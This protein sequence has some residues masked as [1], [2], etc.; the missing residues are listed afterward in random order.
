MRTYFILYLSVAFFA[1]G[2]SLSTIKKNTLNYLNK[3]KVL[4]SKY[5]SHS[6]DKNL[7]AVNS[8]D[9]LGQLKNIRVKLKLGKKEKMDYLHEYMKSANKKVLDN[10]LSSKSKTKKIPKSSI[11]KVHE[12]LKN[13]AI[14]NIKDNPK[15]DK[16]G[17]I[18]F[19]FG[20]SFYTHYLLR[21]I[22][23][24]Q[25]DIAKIF[26]NGRLNYNGQLWDY[27]MATMVKSDKNE[28]WVVDSLF[29]EPIK[30]KKWVKLTVMFG[31]KKEKS[32]AR[33]FITDPRK[34]QSQYGAYEKKFFEI[35]DL[36]NY[37]DKLF[38][39]L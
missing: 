5:Y 33:I 21:K 25:I 1:Y 7:Q 19:C 36:K 16:R 27:H 39:A 35:P 10:F 34:Y 31:I 20:R 14:I 4:S 15:Y 23:A 38:L 9:L 30:L 29:T 26:V 11:M 13:H 22:G 8:K 12:K 17:D 37:F 2:K 28:W 6:V 18:G 3:G 32:Q 24:S